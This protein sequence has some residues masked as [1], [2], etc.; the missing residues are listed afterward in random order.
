MAEEQ[1][2]FIETINAIRAALPYI[3]EASEL[4][5]KDIIDRLEDLAGM[6]ISLITDDLKK[7][8][9]LG[10]RKIDINLALNNNS[11]TTPVTYSKAEITLNDGTLLIIEFDNGTGGVLELSS[12]GDIKQYIEASSL[13]IN[14]VVNTEFVSIDAIGDTP[15]ILRIRDTD[16]SASNIDRV[17]LTAYNGEYIDGKPAYFWAKTTSSL[18]TLANRVGDIIALGQRIDKIIAL[19]DKEGEIQYLYDTRANLQALYDELAKLIDIY[20]NLDNIAAVNAN[21]TNI[22]NVANNK[23]NIDIVAADMTSVKDVSD[24]METVLQVPAKTDQVVQIRDEL[25]AINPKV[26]TIASNETASLSYDKNTGNFTLYMPQG[27]KGERGEAFDVDASGTL[28]N[29]TAY[30][31]AAQ[32]F[33]YLTLDESPTMVYFKKSDTNADWT[34]GVP[35]GQGEKGDKGDTGVS[36]TDISFTSTTDASG[37]AGQASAT[38]TYTIAFSDTSTHTIQVY[39]GA[40]MTNSTLVDD[41]TTSNSKVWSS[42]KTSSEINALSQSVADDLAALD[43]GSFS[44]SNTLGDVVVAANTNVALITPVTFNS[45]TVNDDGRLKLI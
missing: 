4:F 21:K 19:A 43:T 34:T 16:G 18:Q 35:F 25:I 32:G 41:A 40:D 17:E 9:Y 45:L 42:Q 33:A 31:G 30:D 15:A 2:S 36:V 14:N 7:S 39:N 12:H 26:V 44:N 8:N 5:D 23:T 22:D 10:N 38:D 13:Y 1:Y 6:D 27:L 37:Q 24:N 11:E 20:S 29:R 28:A 3:K